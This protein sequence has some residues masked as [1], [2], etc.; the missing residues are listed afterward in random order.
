MIVGSLRIHSLLCLVGL[1]IS[2]VASAWEPRPGW[3]DSYAVDGICY[4]DSSNYDHGIGT[5]KLMTSDG[6]RRSVQQICTD[7][8]SQFGV[9][10]V[11]G[12]I[13]Y[14]TIACGNA[15]ANDAPDEDLVTGCPG[16]VDRGEAGC[17]DLGPEWP[18]DKIYSAPIEGLDRSTWQLTASNNQKNMAAMAD[19]NSATRWSTNVQQTPGQWIEVDLGGLYK[20]NVVDLET[21][22][23][24]HDFPVGWMLEVSSDGDHWMVAATSSPAAVKRQLQGEIT[25]LQFPETHV[26]YLRITQ[27]GHSQKYYW[28]VHELYIGQLSSK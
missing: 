14:N 8:Q 19:G 15:P 21:I 26:Q 23:S 12:R 7:I 24:R 5:I 4:C 13:P 25:R 3:R 27:T 1:L 22:D 9:G 6:Y 11:E 10:A 28:S 2:G 18:L 20:I 16:R 17:F